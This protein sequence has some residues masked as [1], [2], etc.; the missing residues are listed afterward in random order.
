MEQQLATAGATSGVTVIV[1]DYVMT[2]EST[3]SLPPG[4]FNF[5]DAATTGTLAVLACAGSRSSVRRKSGLILF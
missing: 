1:T 5:N 3:I 4:S 2:V